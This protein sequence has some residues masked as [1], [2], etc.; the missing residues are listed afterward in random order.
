MF[1]ISI[2]IYTKHDRVDSPL[3]PGV[4][5]DAITFHPQTG[6]DL[7]NTMSKGG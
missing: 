1:E 5:F 3:Y 4:P 2:S 7:I 6:S